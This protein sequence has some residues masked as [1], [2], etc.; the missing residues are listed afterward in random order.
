M[1]QRYGPDFD[2]IGS[3]LQGICDSI[4][5]IDLQYKNMGLKYHCVSMDIRE[6]PSNDYPVQQCKVFEVAP[7][8]TVPDLIYGMRRV[9]Q[10]FR[11]LKEVIENGILQGEARTATLEQDLQELQDLMATLIDNVAEM[12]TFIEWLDAQQHDQD[13]MSD[14]AVAKGSERATNMTYEQLENLRAWHF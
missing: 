4:T 7:D 6:N 3:P 5:A 11:D 10:M 1:Q 9:A 13:A 12:V 2:T 14:V 8:D